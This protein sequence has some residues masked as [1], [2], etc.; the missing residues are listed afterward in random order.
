MAAVAEEKKKSKYACLDRCHLFT[1]VAVETSGVFCPVTMQF[2]REL[3]Q[4][5]CQVSSDAKSYSSL[6]QRLSVV[7]QQGN[8]A[9]VMESTRGHSPDIDIDFS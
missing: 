7:V 9:S 8:R 2:L 4:R 6:I 5:L 1:P 3:G